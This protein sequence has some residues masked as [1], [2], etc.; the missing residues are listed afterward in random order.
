MKDE[1]VDKSL[2]RQKLWADLGKEERETNCWWQGA[3][4]VGEDSTVCWA[5]AGQEAV[6]TA[7]R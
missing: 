7:L 2:V 5:E 4:R 3:E 1:H 6:G